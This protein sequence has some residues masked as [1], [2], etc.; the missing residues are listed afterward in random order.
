MGGRG[1]AQRGRNLER[2]EAGGRFVRA[3]GGGR[4][5]VFDGPRERKTAE[6]AEVGVE[7]FGFTV[8]AFAQRGFE[9]LKIHALNVDHLGKTAFKIA[10]KLI[11]G[12]ALFE[13]G[14]LHQGDHL[15]DAALEF[16]FVDGNACCAAER[17][18]RAS[19]PRKRLSAQFREKSLHR[20]SL[21]AG[22]V[23][24]ALPDRF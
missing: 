18:R 15:I 11:R 24:D 3:C 2:T 20:L 7:C 21:D 4:S 10:S 5:G 22:D 16:V 1:F 13:R 12:E 14:G 19:W 23:G 17:M 8:E 9:R 6:A